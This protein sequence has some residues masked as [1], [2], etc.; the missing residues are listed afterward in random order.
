MDGITSFVA[1][2]R[3]DIRNFQK[4]VAT[5]QKEA[6]ALPDEIQT[7]VKANTSDYRRSLLQAEALA[8][9]FSA[10]DIVK[11]VK[12][13][14]Q[15]ARTNMRN[16]ITEVDQ[17]NDNFQHELQRLAK[18]ISAF[19]T[20]F[21]NVIRG[22]LIASSMALVP[23]IGGLIGAVMALG[24]ALGVV[25]GGVL[26][27]VGALAT[28]GIGAVAYGGLVTSVLSRYNDEAFEASDASN[29]FSNALE[30]IKS[31]W[32]GIVD[33]NID[34]VFMTMGQAIYAANSALEQMQPFIEGVV[35]SVRGM[36]NEMKN[37]INTSPTMERF[38]QNLNDRGVPVFEDI[39]R[40]I[41]KFTQGIVDM[42]N[43]GMPLIEY[44]AQGFENLGTR[45]S[46]W[47]NRMA[48][49]NGFQNFTDYVQENLPKIGSIFGSTFEGITNLFAAFGD[50]SQV[51]FDR[52]V[53]MSEAFKTWSSNIKESDGFQKFIDYI[54]ENGPTVMSLIGNIVEAVWNFG[55]AVAP[56]AS[57]VLGVANAIADWTG[58]LF[59]A[60]PIVAQIMAVITTLIGV[61][62]ALVPPVLLVTKVILPLISSILRFTGIASL[63]KIGLGLLGKAFAFLLGPV[64]VIIGVIAIL[65]TAFVALYQNNER[66][67]NIVNSVWSFVVEFITS[68]IT[69]IVTKFNEFR[70]EGQGIFQAAWSTF[71]SI[72]TENLTAILAKVVA[73]FL[74]IK[75]N[76]QQKWNRR[77]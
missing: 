39:V 62:M 61:F 69:R 15:N 9:I 19:G 54:Q 45:F 42:F 27:F 72:F 2:I 58:K 14:F 43:A 68:T 70:S 3:A 24:N 29:R 55:A 13:N 12:L 50:N 33:E 7:E 60:H 73:K 4:N 67:R 46:E 47:S 8:K 20:V 64:G 22:S 38:F 65:T 5:A 6:Q 48:E 30:R 56:L 63:L 37:F 26:G 21:G 28:A 41:G 44:V 40:G 17:M 23:V 74:E 16:F 52:L 57:K 75:N 11:H 66:F 18:T 35:G 36:T 71:K 59:E 25:V 1:K 76:I 10:K 49:E 53:E 51:I 77:R 31:T 32:S 34:A